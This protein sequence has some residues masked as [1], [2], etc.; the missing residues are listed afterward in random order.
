MR[1]LIELFK[2]DISF[3]TDEF[4]AYST[5]ASQI[6]GEP[7]A[8]VWPRN[9]EQI[10]KLVQIALRNK[11]T[12]VP[13]GAG[14]GL[15]GGCV[16]QKAIVVDMSKM[17]KIESINVRDNKVTVQPGVVISDLNE[18]LDSYDLFFPV[19]P[20]SHTACQIGGIISTNAVGTRA[21]RFGRTCD[22]VHEVRIVDGGGKLLKVRPSDICGTEGILGIIVEATLKVTEP[23]PQTTLT[24][25]KYDHVDEID[26][27]EFSDAIA[28]EFIDKLS[29]EM[30][31]LEPAY[32]LFSEYEEK[33]E[34]TDPERIKELWGLRK[35]LGPL[36]TTKRY[37]IKEDPKIPLENMGKFIRWVTN[38]KIP[39]F[40]HIG[41]G[42]L[43]LRFRKEQEKL[44]RQMFEKVIELGGSASGE[45]GIGLAKKQYVDQKRIRELTA[46]KE[47]FDPE[48]VFNRGKIYD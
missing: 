33:G 22:W 32:Y 3:D 4:M 10:Q 24:I 45:H 6:K 47:R 23:L 2:E 14:T 25:R 1:K 39:A 37:K 29:A 44:I 13:R 18:K 46:L 40:G 5:D 35:R 12:L 8:I 41:V 7:I 21:L 38:N 28:L 11:H 15:A 31:D 26:F 9:V 20:A 36:L 16:P 48:K 34:I 42:I 17:N 43:H 27:G 30:L 19:I